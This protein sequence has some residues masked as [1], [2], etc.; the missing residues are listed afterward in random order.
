MSIF[1]SLFLAYFLCLN[2]VSSFSASLGEP[3]P[4]SV[5]Q[6]MELDRLVFHSGLQI[7]WPAQAEAGLIEALSISEGQIHHSIIRG[8]IPNAD[9]EL[10]AFEDQRIR[11]QLHLHPDFDQ[12]SFHLVVKGANWVPWAQAWQM[13]D[14]SAQYRWTTPVC[15]AAD[16]EQGERVFYS[17]QGE[18]VCFFLPTGAPG[19]ARTISWEQLP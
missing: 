18:H 4:D 12:G 10:E 14:G 13:T 3:W 7:S 6:V 8:L 15:A 11:Y 2:P 9:L 1:H 19:N 16:L 17:V 5:F